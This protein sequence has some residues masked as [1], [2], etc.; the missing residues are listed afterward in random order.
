MWIN[1]QL[2]ESFFF[3][4]ISFKSWSCKEDNDDENMMANLSSLQ[5]IIWH[6]YLKNRKTE[7]QGIVPQ[8]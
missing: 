3:I 5:V 7:N 8:I 4:P 1:S 6:S 2:L